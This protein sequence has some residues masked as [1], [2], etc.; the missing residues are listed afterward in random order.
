M[1]L[2]SIICVILNYPSIDQKFSRLIWST[3]IWCR[4]RRGSSRSTCIISSS[5]ALSGVSRNHSP[6][7]S[8]PKAKA[9]SSLYPLTSSISSWC[10]R[11]RPTRCSSI[12]TETTRFWANG[13]PNKRRGL[14]LN[15][16]IKLAPTCWGSKREVCQWS[17][18]TMEMFTIRRTKHFLRISLWTQ[19]S[20]GTKRCPSQRPSS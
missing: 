12:Q 7:P 5:W 18:C 1:T 6:G 16:F 4:S 13:S 19:Q 8:L 11:R 3:L 20:T 9:I 2:I 14:R 15:L 10:S 17:K